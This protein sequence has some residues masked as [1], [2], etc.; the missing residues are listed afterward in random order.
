MNNLIT[1]IDPNDKN[2]ENLIEEINRLRPKNVW[3]GCST[4]SGEDV[5]KVFD[6]LK[7]QTDLYPG[8]LDQI[9]K[10]HEIAKHIHIPDPLF[11]SNTKI[12][13][14]FEEVSKY[15]EVNFPGKYNMMNYV[16]L[17]PTCTTAKIL[18]VKKIYNDKEVLNEFEHKLV[19]PEIY[20]EGGSR[21]KDSSITKRLDL[22]KII[23]EKYPHARIICGG[24]ISSLDQIKA[25]KEIDVYIVLSNLIH[26]NPNL[27]G[28][29]MKV[30]E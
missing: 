10:S 24:G 12:S 19:H 13:K 25:L 8:S 27:L 6:K 17:H 26:A 14:L 4:S 9:K 20:L 7:V 16:L 5:K 21:N 28:E 29:Y 3:V 30:L 22:I 1:L 2:L 15:A 18:D 11:Y 23:K